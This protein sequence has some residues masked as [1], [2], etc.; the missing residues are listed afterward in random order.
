MHV[1]V[2]SDGVVGGGVVGGGVAYQRCTPTLPSLRFGTFSTGVPNR[3]AV[4]M[5]SV[6]RAGA[7]PVTVRRYSPAC[8]DSA[9]SR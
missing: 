8:A 3:S 4:P 7:K 6:K 2:V 9:S 5:A 1:V